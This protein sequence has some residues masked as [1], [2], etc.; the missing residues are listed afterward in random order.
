MTSATCTGDQDPADVTVASGQNVTC[1]FTNKYTGSSQNQGT[2]TIRK[3][4][5]QTSD[6]NPDDPDFNFNVDDS[7]AATLKI[8]G[9]MQVPVVPGQHSVEEVG[10]LPTNWSL[11][12]VDCGDNQNPASVDVGSNENVI[13]TF[14]NK[15]SRSAATTGTIRLQKVRDPNSDSGFN[16]PDFNFDVDNGDATPTLKAGD[17]IDIPVT[18][19]QHTVQELTPPANWALTSVDCG[20]SDQNPATFSV[21]A[22]E[23]VECTFTNR[24]SDSGTGNIILRKVKDANSKPGADNPFFN[25]SIDN[26][27]TKLKVGNQTQIQV[28]AGQHTVTELAPPQGWALTGVDCGDNDN[29]ATVTVAA[30][31]TVTCTFTNAYEAKSGK[32]TIKKV[33]IGGDDNF[34]FR[35][36]GHPSFALRNGQE[37]VFSALPAGQYT[38]RETD[39][40]KGWTLQN[41]SCNEPGTKQGNAVSISVSNGDKI[42]CTFTNFKK[43]DDTMRD[44]TNLFVHRRVDNLLTYGPDRAR[45]LRRL[46]KPTTP[47]AGATSSG[48]S[49]T[50]APDAPMAYEDPIP[51][52][53]AGLPPSGM[54]LGATPSLLGIPGEP[55]ISASEGDAYGAPRHSLFS[56]FGTQFL[57]LAAGESS[58]KFSTSLSEMRATA[59]AAAAEEQQQKLKAAGLSYQEQ[60]YNYEYAAIQQGFDVWVEGHLMHYNDGLG[61]ISRDGDFGI[62][63]AGVDYVLQPGVLIGALV[64]VDNTEEDIDDPS[65]NGEIDGTGW[66][67]GPYIGVRLSDF[68][69]FDARGAWG[70]SNNDIWISDAAAGRRKADFDTDRWLATASLTGNQYYG[71]WRL[72]PQVSIA[73]GNESYDT[74]TNSLAQIVSGSDATI[75]RLSGAF[76]IGYQFNTPSGLTIEPEVAITGIWNFDTDNIPVGGVL[77]DASQDRG[78]IDAGFIAR[79]PSGWALRAAGTYDGIGANDFEAYGGS[80]WLSVPLN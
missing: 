50:P 5:D 36:S 16:D 1:T 70:T 75:G 31:E 66:M 64:Q 23:I 28:V 44:V 71:P 15:Y 40:P 30:D 29:P 59:A 21:S 11:T 47:A 10:P 41:I 20:G 19:G 32:L 17:T 13:C 65:V 80:L 54:S 53:N 58:F 52:A 46:E 49:G 78:K 22:D 45:L 37:Q 60:P 56:S 12:N 4:L 55:G 69:F 25:F 3:V 34:R 63:Y 43:E 6:P 26:L 72:S 42:V 67:A 9:E 62:L 61:G 7:L 76:E 48:F 27:G 33:A 8:N 68:L 77:Y 18:P 35:L 74:Y 51:G 79:T 57:P 24:Y 39:L 38:I 73:Y 2:I 14:T